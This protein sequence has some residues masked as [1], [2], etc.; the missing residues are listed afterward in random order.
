MA[1]TR[2]AILDP[3]GSLEIYDIFGYDKCQ[4]LQV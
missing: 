2:D 4:D 1:Q 3:I